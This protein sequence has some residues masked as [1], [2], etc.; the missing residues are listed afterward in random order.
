[1]WRVTYSFLSGVLIAAMIT[2]GV[3]VYLLHDVDADRIGKWNLAYWELSTEF[4][5][6]ALIV[7]G[8]FLTVT[9]IGSLLLHV[10]HA[11]TSSKLPF[12]LG[13]GLILIQYPTEFAVR[14]LSAAHSADTF[15]LTYLLLS[16]VC[17]AAII[18]IDRYRTAAATANNVS[19]A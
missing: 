15:L 4:F 11:P 19:Q 17:C 8:V 3:A 14:K 6:F 2:N 7:L 18:L 10:R 13:V 1:M 12:V 9:W 16:P 5:F